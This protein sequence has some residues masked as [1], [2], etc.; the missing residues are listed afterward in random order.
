MSTAHKHELSCLV[1]PLT[2]CCDTPVC[3]VRGVVCFGN[4]S[5]LGHE[6]AHAA[7][8]VISHSSEGHGR[9]WSGWMQQIHA[10]YPGFDLSTRH[11]YA[12][13]KPFQ[14]RCQACNSVESRHS[15]SVKP[16][17]SCKVC[18]APGRLDYLGKFDKNG[19]PAKTRGG[20]GGGGG[21]GGGKRNPYAEFTKLHMKDIARSLPAGTPQKQVMVEVGRRWRE[22]KA[23]LESASAVASTASAEKT[24]AARGSSSVFASGGSLGADATA[25]DAEFARQLQAQFAAAES[26]GGGLVVD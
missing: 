13:H 10:L 25:G 18:G 5:T 22:H 20:A 1:L 6:L 26:I 19:T 2:C 12:I 3:L 24:M 15:K 8:W 11:G 21:G 23:Q 4:H 17:D 14:W 16:T 7:V 9:I